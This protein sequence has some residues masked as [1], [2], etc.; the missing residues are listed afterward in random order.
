MHQ[1]EKIP[2]FKKWSHWYALLVIVL[3]GLIVFFTW[4]TKHFS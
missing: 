3:V 1:D 4:F 2:L